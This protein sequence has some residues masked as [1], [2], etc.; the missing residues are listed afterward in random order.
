MYV[1]V[2]LLFHVFDFF[3]KKL[4]NLLSFQ[5]SISSTHNAIQV[6]FF[7]LWLLKSFEVD[8]LNLFLFFAFNTALRYEEFVC[9]I[10]GEFV[11]VR[12]SKRVMG[13]DN[14]G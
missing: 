2:L 6:S 10:R 12:S 3:S 4:T 13:G 14:A 1:F 8:F 9:F 5:M 7:T 11:F